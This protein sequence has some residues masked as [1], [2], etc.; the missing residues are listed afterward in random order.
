MNFYYLGVG[1]ILIP[2]LIVVKKYFNIRK[3]RLTDR[4]LDK[5]KDL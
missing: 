3:T 1:I 5:Y 4:Q 2:T